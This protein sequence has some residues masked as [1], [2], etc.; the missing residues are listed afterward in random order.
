MMGKFQ[1]YFEPLF[2]RYPNLF[3]QIQRSFILLTGNLLKILV[4]LIA[5]SLLLRALKPDQAGQMTLVLNVVGVFSVIGEFGLRDAAVNYIARYRQNDLAQTVALTRAFFVAKLFFSLAASSA[6]LIGAG[7]IS[8]RFYQSTDITP[9]VHIAAFTLLTNGLL[10]FS[11]AILEAHQKF[12][13]ISRLNVIQ[14]SIRAAL[15]AYLFWRQQLTLPIFFIFESVLPLLVFLYTLHLQPIP[16]FR[17]SLMSLRPAWIMLFGFTKWLIFSTLFAVLVTRIDVL[18]L[19]YYHTSVVVGLYAATQTLIVR[20]N[21][22]KGPILTTAFAEACHC[23]TSFEQKAF[24]RGTLILT[25][26]ITLLMIPLVIWGNFFIPLL[27]GS[28]YKQDSS[29]FIILLISFLLSLNIEPISYL[30]FP[31]NKAHLIAL[32]NLVQLFI[33]FLI[34]VWLIPK[35][36]TTG[37]ALTV[38]AN[39]FVFTFLTIGLIARYL[40]NPDKVKGSQILSDSL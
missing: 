37:A 1:K 10:G 12:S 6:A 29:T 36:G 35:F 20:L 25:G 7:W 32:R 24:I 2:T 11:I 31:L 27:F 38:L 34:G 9:L 18:L 21:F 17:K 14:A 13:L 16:D 33:T 5:S 23:V 8:N 22:I 4:G 15:I 39:T 19:S 40:N 3:Q 30:L 26:G 28:S